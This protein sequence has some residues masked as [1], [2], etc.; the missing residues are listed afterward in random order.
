[1][2]AETFR[3]WIDDKTRDLQ[4]AATSAQRLN[5][6]RNIDRLRDAYDLL[7]EKKMEQTILRVLA[8]NNRQK[9]KCD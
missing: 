6:K 1:L 4:N 5:L 3:G 2:T 8:K 9:N 7:K